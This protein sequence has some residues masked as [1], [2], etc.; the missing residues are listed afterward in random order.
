MG[1]DSYLTFESDPPEV[2]QLQ[3]AA[4]LS[5]ADLAVTKENAKLFAERFPTVKP[6]DLAWGERLFDRE[7]RDAFA[8]SELPKMKMAV[9]T[10]GARPCNRCGAITT[11]FCEGCPHP[12]PFALCQRCDKER[13]L[14]A[15]CIHE[16]KLW[17][18]TRSTSD[19]EVMEVSGYNNDLGEFT[20]LDPPLRLPTASIPL[21][22][23]VMDLEF[24]TAKIMEH[25]AAQEARQQAS[26]STAGWSTQ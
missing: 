3:M 7:A 11:S 4:A 26:A 19:P 18:A 12:A 6:G 15:R 20:A 2:D 5:S 21:V 17:S 23:G 9:A 16:G 8:I 1:S 24:V 22:D 10:L 14:C 13:L 25:R